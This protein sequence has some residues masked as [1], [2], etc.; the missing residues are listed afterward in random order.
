MDQSADERSRMGVG[1]FELPL[2]QDDWPEMLSSWTVL[3]EGSKERWMAD[4]E[5]I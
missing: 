2:G 5:D 1:Q 3:W 4:T